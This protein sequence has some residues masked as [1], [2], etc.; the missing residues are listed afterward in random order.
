MKLVE[1]PKYYSAREQ[2]LNSKISTTAALA[3]FFALLTVM[4]FGTAIAKLFASTA[5]PVTLPFSYD[6]HMSGSLAQASSQ[7]LSSSAYWWLTNGGSFTIANGVGTSVVGSQATFEL[8]SRAPVANPDVQIYFKKSADNFANLTSVQGYYG[9]SLIFGFIDQQNYYLATLRD[10]GGVVIK[11]KVNGAYQTLGYKKLLPGTWNAVTSPDL[12]P[13]NQWIGLKATLTSDSSGHPFISF[14]TDIGKTGTWALALQAV[15]DPVKYG[16]SFT[17]AGLTGFMSDFSNVQIDD[18]SLALASAPT[19][20]PTTPPP[21]PPPVDS[22]I[23]FSDP[24]SEYADGLITNE[25]AYWSPTSPGAKVSS[26]WE[27]DSGSLFAQGGNGWTGV[28]NIGV[29]NANSSTAND[30]SIF[31]LTTKEA[32]F[33]NVA[34]DFDLLNQGLSSNATTPAVSWDGLHVFLRYQTEYNLYYAS[35]NRRDNTAVIK[36]KIPGGPSNN[37]T[38]YELVAYKPHTVRYNAWQHVKATVKNNADGSVTINLYADGQLVTTATDNGTI[39]GAPITH[40]G[41]VGVR[42]DNANLKFKNFTVTA[43]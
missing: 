12:I 18:F 3:V 1:S 19:T 31:R 39:G 41:K 5:A 28:P 17:S 32:D 23:L 6:F 11:K 13:L 27:L 35:I 26:K 25:Y 34:V 42:G 4:F 36:K 16:A 30:S 8:L 9:Q 22:K 37:G 33:G 38:Y 21:P 43:L 40:A 14:Y 2:E 24:F 20:N 29:P 10:D 7:S 15:D